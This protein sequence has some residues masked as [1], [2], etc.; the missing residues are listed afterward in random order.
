MKPNA[1]CNNLGNASCPLSSS[2]GRVG[3]L[4]GPSHAA[5]IPEAADSPRRP[6]NRTSQVALHVPTCLVSAPALRSVFLLHL[7]T[8][9]AFTTTVQTQY[10]GM[11]GVTRTGYLRAPLHTLP[12]MSCAIAKP[13]SFVL[14]EI[15]LRHDNAGGSTAAQR[16]IR[17]RRA[18][19]T[20]RYPYKF[21]PNSSQ[22][23]YE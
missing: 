6:V 13:T 5:I 16:G 2:D 17:P 20:A 11:R 14:L 18:L 19:S 21:I 9:T 1:A 22:P 12:L 15:S 8:I 3:G 23:T 7:E 10:D 4:M